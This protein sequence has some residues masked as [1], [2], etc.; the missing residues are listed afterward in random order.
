[1]PKQVTFPS[2]PLTPW[3][4]NIDADGNELNNASSIQSDEVVFF[5]LKEANHQVRVLTGGSGYTV[6]TDVPVTGGSGSGMTVDISNV[7]AGGELRT[8]YLAPTINNPGTGYK[9]DDV[10][11]VGGSGTG[12]TF[13]FDAMV[14]RKDGNNLKLETLV[15]ASNTVPFHI[16]LPNPYSTFKVSTQGT[17]RFEVGLSRVFF[18]PTTSVSPLN[19]GKALGEVGREWDLYALIGYFKEQASQTPLSGYGS[20]FAKVVDSVAVP[21]SL[22]DSDFSAPLGQ[23]S[24]INDTSDRSAATGTAYPLTTGDYG[25]TVR[26]NNTG[27][28][29][30]DTQISVT[31][32]STVDF[33]IGTKI[34][35]RDMQGVMTLVPMTGVTVNDILGAGTAKEWVLE[36]VAS[37]EW[38]AIGA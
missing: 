16:D 35:L 1:M 11:A 23:T 32:E 7:L 15:E 36:K 26:F 29:S 10:L 31:A 4:E 17:D 24:I 30:G 13:S 27:T 20:I 33:P 8:D 25:R 22:T 34:T 5:P 38:D 18:N 37:N 2:K 14:M 6:A 12:G 28:G 9:A 3:T 21:H 19:A